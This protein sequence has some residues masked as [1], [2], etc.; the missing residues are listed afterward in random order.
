MKKSYTKP[1]LRTFTPTAAELAGIIN[2]LVKQASENEI[3]IQ[4]QAERIRD[5]EAKLFGMACQE[6]G[7][8]QSGPLMIK[9]LYCATC[10]QQMA[11]SSGDPYS[12][13]HSDLKERI[14]DLEAAIT[15]AQQKLRATQENWHEDCLFE[16]D[17]ILTQALGSQSP[18]P[19]ILHR[20]R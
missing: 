13:P 18:P 10:G 6:C 17:A 19:Q 15:S 8:K 4:G 12:G 3:L 2:T 14:R 5:L 20:D 11:R 9:S 7:N 1:E 16:C